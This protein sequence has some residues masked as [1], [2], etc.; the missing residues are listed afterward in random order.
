MIK[1]TYDTLLILGFVYLKLYVWL[2][3]IFSFFDK[4]RAAS[5][6]WVRSIH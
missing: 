3:M 5:P 6:G 4:G 2:K 1:L